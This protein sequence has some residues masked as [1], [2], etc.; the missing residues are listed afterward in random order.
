MSATKMRKIFTIFFILLAFARSADAQTTSVTQTITLTIVNSI[1]LTFTGSGT[2]TGSTVTLPFAS[3]ADY[4]NGVTSADQAM[5][6]QS[7]KSFN[8]SIKSS[9]TNFT[10]TGSVTPTP[11]VSIASVLQ[12]WVSVNSTGGSLS[13]TTYSY[14]PSGSATL[15][16][17]G[18]NG[19]S[20]TFSVR[21]KALPGFS[22]PGGTYTA[23]ILYTATQ[24]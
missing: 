20:E 4:S 22:L 8:V 13:Y 11:T 14:I 21:Y 3:V 15:I 1:G 23:S 5:V 17:S 6:V 12:V 18:S 19:A 2:S 10:Y 9:S 24:L 7:N 16:N